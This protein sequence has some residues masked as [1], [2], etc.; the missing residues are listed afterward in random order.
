MSSIRSVLPKLQPYRHV[1]YPFEDEQHAINAVFL[2]ASSK[3]SKGESVVLVMA[4][5]RCEPIT[6]RLAQAGFDLGALEASGQLECIDIQAMLERCKKIGTLD[7][8]I[9]MD[10]TISVITR[11]S[12]GT[13]TEFA[14]MVSLIQTP[15]QPDSNRVLKGV[16]A[17][18]A[19]T[20]K[21]IALAP[22]ERSRPDA[23]QPK[24]RTRKPGGKT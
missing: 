22:D 23:G 11:E 16:A 19:R 8:R 17:R 14:E 2:F 13:A 5:S 1:V 15:S 3:L 4:D 24:R 7:Q 6:G 20:V 21:E 9:V 12:S 10:A 18:E